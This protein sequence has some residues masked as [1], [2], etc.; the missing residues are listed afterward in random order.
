MANLYANDAS[1]TLSAGINDSVT[2]VNVTDGS[3]FPSPKGL[4]G[5]YLT[6][7]DGTNTEIIYC[8]ARSGNTLTVVRGVD[9]SSAR[10]WLSGDEVHLRLN[11]AAM[12]ELENKTSLAHWQTYGGFN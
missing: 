1:T 9:G 5:F 7:M 8:T 2:T 12:A 10:S 11:Q 4:T 6:L 3:V